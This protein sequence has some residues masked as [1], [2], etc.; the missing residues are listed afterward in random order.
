LPV[1]GTDLFRSLF[2]PFD[3]DTFISY[4][5]KSLKDTKEL[6]SAEVGDLYNVQSQSGY[7]VGSVEQDIWKT[8][9][10]TVKN[11]DQ[12]ITIQAIV[13]FTGKDIN[14]DDMPHGTLEGNNI[15]SAKVMIGLFSD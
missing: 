13:G 12:S 15:R 7:I 8:G 6:Y 2:S 9:V 5:R 3:N 14:R 11:E 1:E 4:D 10:H